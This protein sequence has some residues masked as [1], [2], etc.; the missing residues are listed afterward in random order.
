[1]RKMVRL[2]SD[3]C[4]LLLPHT[5]PVHVLYKELF[6]KAMPDMKPTMDF[7]MFDLNLIRGIFQ[8]STTYE[9]GPTFLDYNNHCTG[10]STETTALYTG[11][12]KVQ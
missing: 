4:R 6:L 8:V 11:V 12:V 5:S 7:A 10:P 1:M 3:Q 2:R 9:N